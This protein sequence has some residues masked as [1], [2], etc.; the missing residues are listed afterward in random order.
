MYGQFIPSRKKPLSVFRAQH[1]EQ[2]TLS[3]T[4]LV[5]KEAGGDLP[6]L[7]L[8]RW[9]LNTAP[10]PFVQEVITRHWWIMAGEV[11]G[12][13]PLCE[14]SQ[15]SLTLQGKG[16]EAPMPSRCQ[17]VLPASLLGHT[18]AGTP[19]LPYC[20]PRSEQAAQGDYP[21]Y[22]APPVGPEGTACGSNLTSGHGNGEELLLPLELPQRVM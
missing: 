16:T 7:L 20:V 14:R 13:Q 9:V 2:F 22:H 15:P 3:L 1:E 8:S 11:D 6:R 12:R 19:K 10:K 18:A 5:A 17:R 21:L 4:S